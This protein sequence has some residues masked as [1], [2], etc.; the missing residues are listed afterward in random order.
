MRKHA[1]TPGIK[2]CEGLKVVV[3]GSGP[4]G[5][6]QAIELTLLKA[7]VHVIEQRTVFSRCVSLLMFSD[8]SA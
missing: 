2:S 6:R 8:L 3:V 7:E 1:S 4:V 5:L